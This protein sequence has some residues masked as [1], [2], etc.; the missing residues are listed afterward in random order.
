MSKNTDLGII[1]DVSDDR[2]LYQADAMT[3]IASVKAEE[4]K[5]SRRSVLSTRPGNNVG[6]FFDLGQRM[7]IY[8]PEL[9]I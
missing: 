8:T 6:R 9:N 2:V 7:F 1:A 5:T 3:R 4:T